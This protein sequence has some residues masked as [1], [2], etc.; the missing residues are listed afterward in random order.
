MLSQVAR[1]CLENFYC[2]YLYDSSVVFSDE[3]KKNHACLVWYRIILWFWR[4]T[5]TCLLS[6]QSVSYTVKPMIAMPP[7]MIRFT[8]FMLMI[9]VSSVC[10]KR[11]HDQRLSQRG[12]H[13][14][15]EEDREQVQ[16]IPYHK[17]LYAQQSGHRVAQGAP[18]IHNYATTDQEGSYVIP[19]HHGRHDSDQADQIV[20]IVLLVSLV[21]IV[22]AVMYFN[23][24]VPE[25]EYKD[26][27]CALCQQSRQDHDSKNR[28]NNNYH[29]LISSLVSRIKVLSG[30]RED[31]SFTWVTLKTNNNDSGYDNLEYDINS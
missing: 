4:R 22:V 13:S 19:S 7:T 21:G 31:V 16:N 29:N 23:I 24:I 6:C 2:W 1:S 12:F 28:G 30:G 9:S 11:H 14:S 25:D 18:V 27:K 20:L 17:V 3:V 26:C 5:D 8:V 10:S 15:R